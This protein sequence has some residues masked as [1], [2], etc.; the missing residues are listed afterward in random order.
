M[1]QACSSDV[2]VREG[3]PDPASRFSARDARQRQPLNRIASLL[4]RIG[5]DT[6]HRRLAGP[7]ITHDNAEI[8]PAGYMFKRGDACSSRKNQCTRHRAFDSPFAGGVRH[9]VGRPQFE[10]FRG[11]VQPFFDFQHLPGGEAFLAAAVVNQAQC[12]RGRLPPPTEPP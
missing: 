2:I 8:A 7:G 11:T 9:H 12:A 5:G 10:P 3:M 6:Q 1:P 4:I